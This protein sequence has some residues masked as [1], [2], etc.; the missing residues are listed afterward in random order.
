MG[1]REAQI[2]DGPFP[3][4][5]QVVSGDP[6]APPH[7]KE[8]WLQQVQPGEFA[9]RYKGF[10]TGLP[11]SPGG[12]HV[13]SSEICRIF[14]SLAEAR[15]NSRQIAQAHWT[16]RCFIYDHTGAEID[17]IYNSGQVNKLAAAMYLGVL[18]QVAAYTLAGTAIVWVV[19][20]LIVALLLP[21]HAP[22]LHWIRGIALV[23]AG[24]GAAVLVWFLQLRLT[25]ARQVKASL[26]KVRA[27][28]TPEERKRFEELNTLF[29]TPDP[30]KRQRFLELMSEY[31]Q[32][33]RA[34]LRKYP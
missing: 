13:R 29:G 24:L 8:V 11:H 15:E 30:V 33:L 14:S 16:T 5:A 17:S 27:A 9:V 20:R 2:Y 7:P 10:K 22:P 23:T 19:Y 25:A 32:R 3:T 4:Y 28:F 6:A 1:Y 12:A 21:G 34:A 18:L 26:K 31:R